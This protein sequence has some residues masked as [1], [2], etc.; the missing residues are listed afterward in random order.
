MLYDITCMWHLKYNTDELICETE[1]DSDA[2]NRQ[3]VAREEAG[4]GR[5]RMDWQLGLADADYYL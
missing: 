1:T 3:V 5:G 2:E 4:Q